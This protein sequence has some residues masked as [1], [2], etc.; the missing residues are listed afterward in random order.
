MREVEFRPEPALGLVDYEAVPYVLVVESVEHGGEWLR[1]ASY[2]ELPG[3]VAE[4]PSA[5]DAIDK[6]DEERRR[7]LRQLWDDG[8]LIP[9]PRPPLRGPHRPSEAPAG[10]MHERATREA[11]A[12][13]DS[14]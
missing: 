10:T 4:A 3:C 2:P 11:D 5:L 8:A 13:S 9:L 6:L 1:R 14:S 7:L 12:L